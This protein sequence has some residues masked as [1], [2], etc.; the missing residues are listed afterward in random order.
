MDVAE[1]H[2]LDLEESNL[3]LS[4]ST[5]KTTN[6]RAKTSSKSKPKYVPKHRSGGFAILLHCIFMIKIEME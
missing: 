6:K 2:R 1:K 4:T 3:T 5:I